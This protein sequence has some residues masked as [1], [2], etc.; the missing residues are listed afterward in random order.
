LRVS[1]GFNFSLIDGV[2]TA[3]G[4]RTDSC[5]TVNVCFSAALKRPWRE[6]DHSHRT[7]VKANNG[8]VINEFSA[9]APLALAGFM[10]GK[11]FKDLFVL[12]ELSATPG[13][14]TGQWTCR[15]PSYWWCVAIGQLHAPAA[16]HPGERA[17]GIN[18]IEGW[19]CPRAGL[20]DVEK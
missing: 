2:Q 14:R 18:W 4:P 8:V 11:R 9:G 5:K 6:A 20:D 7:S 13:R 12:K 1:V 10:E 15:S 16:L 17:P 3:V 19:V